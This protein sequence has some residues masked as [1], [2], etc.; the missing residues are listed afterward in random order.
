[1]EYVDV[2]P[3]TNEDLMTRW[4]KAE[5]WE[6]VVR[7][8]KEQTAG[9]GRQGRTWT[10]YPNESLT[11]SLAYPFQKN[12]SALSGLSLGI[13]LALID[14]ISNTFAMNQDDLHHKKMRLKWPNDL[15]LDDK[16]LAGILIEGGQLSPEQPTW[17]VIGIGVNLKQNHLQTQLD[18][19]ISCLS[20]INNQAVD[21]DIFLLQVLKSLESIFH[22]FETDNFSKL[23]DNWNHWDAY[24]GQACQILQNDQVT[25]LGIE[26]GVNELGQLRLQTSSGLKMIH[27]GDVS[28]VAHE[29]RE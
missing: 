28:L 6:P 9:R 25:C 14:A 21:A 18:R 11:F 22:V 12:I 20:D 15:L 29:V 23:Q 13:G 27:S 1:M 17:L 5:L 10:S 26:Q 16:K 24:A 3:S 2:S 8:A 19:P 4:R 7:V